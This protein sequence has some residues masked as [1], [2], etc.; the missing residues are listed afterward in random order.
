MNI[1][2]CLRIVAASTRMSVYGWSGG[3]VTS[4]HQNN[5]HDCTSLGD[6]LVA[7]SNF[8]LR[9]LSI[10]LFEPESIA[11]ELMRLPSHLLISLYQFYN[12]LVSY[13][14]ITSEFVDRRQRNSPS[15][16]YLDTQWPLFQSMVCIQD[17]VA[18]KKQ[19]KLKE[20]VPHNFTL[21]PLPKLTN[22]VHKSVMHCK[23]FPRP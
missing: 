17:F 14:I 23:V 4:F 21:I 7:M 15:P 11:S 19:L 2:G 8:L 3:N 12:V 5:E 20:N 16:D 6:D 10:S 13:T 22:K 18:E 9:F 1:G